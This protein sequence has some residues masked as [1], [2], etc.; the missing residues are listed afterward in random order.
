MKGPLESRH[1]SSER[2]APGLSSHPGARSERVSTADRVALPHMLGAPDVGDASIRARCG[3]APHS[4][5]PTGGTIQRSAT[6]FGLIAQRPSRH[7]ARGEDVRS[8]RTAW[9]A[10]HD[11]ITQDPSEGDMGFGRALPHR[12]PSR[13]SADRIRS[14]HGVH[15]GFDQCPPQPGRALARDPSVVD[16]TGAAVDARHHA[17]IIRQRRATREALNVA[18]LRADRQRHDRADAGHLL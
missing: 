12:Q 3:R 15:R 4:G 2:S 1:T 16:A 18:D 9:P 13:P 6:R 5:W 14:F 10:R 8:L 7:S 17:G 11:F